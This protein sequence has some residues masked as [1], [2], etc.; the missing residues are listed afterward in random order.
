MLLSLQ[1]KAPS[2]DEGRGKEPLPIKG[3]TVG[4]TMPHLCLT[5]EKMSA[6]VF[7]PFYITTRGE[8]L[9]LLTAPERHRALA[10]ACG[11]SATERG[12]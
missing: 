5:T 6:K 7:V 2:T 8:A 10:A 4:C 11:V 3:K 1:L 9:S 12:G